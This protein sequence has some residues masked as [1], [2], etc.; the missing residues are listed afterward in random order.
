[1]NNFLIINL[2][3]LLGSITI[4]LA[5]RWWVHPR[6]AS[7]PIEAAL[8]PLVFIHCFRYLGLSFMAK[9]QFYSGFPSAFLATTG[10]WDLATSVLAIVTAIALKQQW[11]FAVPLAWA[12]NVFGFADLVVAFPQFFSLRLY[13]YNLGF[14]WLMFVTYGLLAFLSHLYIFYR[15][16]QNF[17]KPVSFV[18]V[19]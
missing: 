10:L 15:L 16:F 14:I 8:L 4:V 17:R 19:R 7:L 3:A 9:E 6:I 1:M 12:F 5:F 18:E 13:D 11:R 2:Q